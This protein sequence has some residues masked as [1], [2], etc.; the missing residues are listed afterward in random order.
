MGFST[1]VSNL[2]SIYAYGRETSRAGTESGN[3]SG[4][5]STETVDRCNGGKSWGRKMR[6]SVPIMD[7]ERSGIRDCGRDSGAGDKWSKRKGRG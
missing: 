7:T 1:E 6:E 4:V 2:C 3:A 5:W